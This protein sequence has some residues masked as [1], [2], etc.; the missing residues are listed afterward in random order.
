MPAAAERPTLYK[1]YRIEIPL[2]K[3]PHESSSNIEMQ[4][5][6]NSF[7]LGKLFNLENG[8]LFKWKFSEQ[9]FCPI[10]FQPIRNKDNK[11]IKRNLCHT[12]YEERQ[13]FLFQKA[14]GT[15]AHGKIQLSEFNFRRRNLSQQIVKQIIWNYF[16][17]LLYFSWRRTSCGDVKVSEGKAMI[18]MMMLLLSWL[19]QG[20]RGMNGWWKLD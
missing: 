2:E 12:N 5:Y 8:N 19:C 4:I 16:D 20:A 15:F 9:P 17:L 18:L 11:K 3:R 1:Y 7:P 10:L 14:L 13:N 6:M